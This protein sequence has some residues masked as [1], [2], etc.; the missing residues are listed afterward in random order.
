MAADVAASP[1]G[2]AQIKFGMKHVI[3][4]KTGG[5]PKTQ[6]MIVTA[7]LSRIDLRSPWLIDRVVVEQKPKP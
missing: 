2:A 4:M 1:A 5:A 6:D 3:E 7:V